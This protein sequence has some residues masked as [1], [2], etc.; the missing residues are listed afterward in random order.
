[1]APANVHACKCMFPP[2]AKTAAPYASDI[3]EAVAMGEP[4]TSPAEELPR[5][6]TYRFKVG[7]VMKG[8][9]AGTVEL[10]T[11]LSSAACGRTYQAGDTYL[12]YAMRGDQG[13]RDGACS[14]TTTKSKAAARGDYAFWG[15]GPPPAPIKKH[16]VETTAPRPEPAQVSAPLE[17]Q[18]APPPR[19]SA[20]EK[21]KQQEGVKEA[22]ATAKL[23]SEPAVT[24]DGCSVA[25]PAQGDRYVGW[26]LLALCC[27]GFRRRDAA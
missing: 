24:A 2:D 1:M 20:P 16:T 8:T 27:V 23:P 9:A 14:F 21:G 10:T 4:V 15:D 22:A 26:T 18:G 17:P 12:L 5:T 7:R 3:F 19:A 6:V 25:T 11:N 13:L